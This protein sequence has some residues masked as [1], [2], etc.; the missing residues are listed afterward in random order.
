[1]TDRKST[2]QR[3]RK[4][5]SRTNAGRKT[6]DTKTAAPAKNTSAA[7]EKPRRAKSPVSR[8]SPAAKK[9]VSAPAAPLL[10]LSSKKVGKVITEK[11]A[12]A[13]KPDAPYQPKTE[14]PAPTPKHADIAAPLPIPVTRMI[15]P[16]AIATPW[17]RL[18]LQMTL[19]GIAMQT[20][21]ARAALEA[22]RLFFPRTPT[23]SATGAAAAASPV[24]DRAARSSSA[25][26]K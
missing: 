12:E 21:M 10:A 5:S 1:M 17:M 6:A 2:A 13:S 11:V 8:K 19:A 26:R 14:A 4:I 23:P 15:N 3:G 18:G 20:R 9:A 16:L 25:T 7:A 22:P 24:E